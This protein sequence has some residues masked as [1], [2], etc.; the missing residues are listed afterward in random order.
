ME[1][2]VRFQPSSENISEGVVTYWHFEEG[3]EVE[4][5]DDLVEVSCEETTYSIS[6]PISGILVERCVEEGEKVKNG[7]NLAIIETSD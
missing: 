6:C 7:D 5:Y 1:E 3:E 4:E 2:E